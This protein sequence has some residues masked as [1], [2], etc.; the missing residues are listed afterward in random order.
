MR[1]TKLSPLTALL[2][3]ALTLGCLMADEQDADTPDVRADQDLAGARYEITTTGELSRDQLHAIA[4]FVESQGQ[5]V[6]QAK[7]MM[8]L[9]HGESTVLA[10]EMWA[11]EL[12]GEGFASALQQEFEFLADAEVN[13]SE[14]EDGP[15]LHEI[16]PDID[17]DIDPGDPE[18][19]KQRVIDDLRARGVE[20]E[21]EVTITPREDGHYEIEVDV[22]KEHSAG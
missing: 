22:H 3:T 11:G 17:P 16:H 13:V 2:A 12:P 19:I 8:Q 7:V 4:Q 20:G 15:Q 5:D 10:V 1:T 18:T 14:L 21:I 6:H 9:D